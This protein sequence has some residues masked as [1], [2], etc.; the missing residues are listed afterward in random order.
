MDRVRRL[1][2]QTRATGVNCYFNEDEFGKT[3]H[4][5]KRLQD[6]VIRSYTVALALSPESAESQLC[7]ELLQ[8][9]VGNG[10]RLATLILDEDIDV[11]VH[12]SI[13]QN[14][15]VYFR[16]QDDLAAR[17]D[18]LRAY[19]P[20]DDNLKLHTELLVLAN[21]WR[22]RGRPP[23]L[24]LPPDRLEEARH[25]L[26]TASA[27][28]PKPSPLQVE[29]VH[30][31]RRQPPKRRPPVSRRVALGFASLIALGIGAL[32]FQ[33]AL[34]GLGAAQFSGAL[35]NEARTQA[36]LTAEANVAGDGALGLIDEV[37]ATSVSLRAEAAQTATAQSIAATAVA[38]VTGRAQALVDL[39]ATQMRATQITQ[40]ERDEVAK[41]L[42]QA[43][44]DA[45]AQGNAELALA[46]A[47]EAK[48][49]LED[50]EPAYRLLRRAAGNRQSKTLQDLA[51]LRLNP[52]G[53][54][55]ALVPSSRDR[56]QLHDGD[57]W[58]LRHEISDHEG[59]ITAITYSPDGAYLISAA[60]DGEII[61]RDGVNGADQLRLRGHQG[62]VTA[63]AYD[64]ASGRLF[65]A[66][67]EPLLLAWDGA[68]GET[69][70]SYSLDEGD[71]LTIHDLIV[72]GAGGRLIGWSKSGMRQWSAD[73]LEPLGEGDE[74]R[75][76]RGFDAERRIGY[77]G[78]RSLPA[79]PGDSNTGDLVFW[80][81]DLGRER[82]RLTDGFNWSF[83]N[84]GDLSAPVDEARFI[85]FYEDIALIAVD[86]SDGEGRALIVSVD[87]GALQRSFENDFMALLTSAEFLDEETLISATSDRRV[88]LWSASGGGLIREIA[89]APASID[90][91]L[92][93]EGANLVIARTSD[94]A[95]HLWR[96]HDS[97]ADPLLTLREALP[98][99]TISPDGA[100]LLLVEE[101]AVSM[102]EIDTGSIIARISASQI[103]SVEDRFAA[104]REGSLGVYETET[105]AEI[106]SW[107]WNGG[108]VTDLRL[109]PAGA[110][111][112]AVTEA[113]EL[114][115][116]RAESESPQ[117]LA[118]LA[119][120][121]SLIRFA[122]DGE[123]VLTLQDRHAVLWDTDDG[124]ARAAYP[125]GA[126]Y[127]APVQAAFTRDSD[128]IVFYLQLQEGLAALA[129]LNLADNSVRRR[130]F[131]D[132]HSAALS[133]DGERL[134]LAFR[135]G[136]VHIIATANGEVLAQLAAGAGEARKLRHLPEADALITAVGAE[137]ILWDLSAVVLDQ[138]FVHSHPIAEFSISR[139]GT[140]ILS[141][142]DI[143]THRL[144]QVESAQD[145]LKRIATFYA[146]RDLTCA[147]R[148]QYLVA[149][150]C[151]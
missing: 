116:A 18:E 23:D 3:A 2:A 78:G 28:Q 90:A 62:A 55:F 72:T 148:E 60:A 32:L 126:A 69:L 17:V 61:I 112:V 81:L 44:D 68:S 47:W 85:A 39:R 145:L 33:R 7:N 100:V 103:S 139:D 52:A 119:A 53:A 122:P 46:L 6:G 96:I 48:D 12:P 14:P 84:D 133:D 82:V 120:R 124:S 59:A 135:D 105:G 150:L 40:L 43:G 1:A 29:F 65:S 71:E 88:V 80:D 132:A 89:R 15:Y 93:N 128:S 146:P 45:L 31:S 118:R 22:E 136:R 87:D 121:P 130:T 64:A 26:A 76:Y 94:G 144:W 140:R 95:A 149:P 25:W 58:T 108:L 113:N 77:T 109:S 19:L 51:L 141:A 63:L 98:G 79:Y 114:W 4:S 66:G 54:G 111:L 49:G 125:L 9:A 142:D 123:T 10:K 110:L 24:L 50:P 134:S 106:H 5:V 21:N 117:R 30:A 107:D 138:R 37:A 86:N 104:Y 20:A 97:G 102:R 131:V 83:L 92:V 151:E 34:A 75:V 13:A 36:A 115:L 16:E 41:R 57:S 42:A 27:R 67:Q 101:G 99:T 8:F 73:T 70:A 129:T 127:S 147:E 74:E 143:G 137:L 56:L 11:E 35:T 38:Q 91:L